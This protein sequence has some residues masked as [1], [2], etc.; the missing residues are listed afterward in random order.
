MTYSYTL[1]IYKSLL[2]VAKGMPAEK[3]AKAIKQI[4]EEFQRNKLEDNSD[5]IKLLLEKANSSLG[6]LKIVTPRRFEDKAQEG[7]TRIV[8]GED[9]PRPGRA[10][11]NWT[12]TN[13]DPDSVDRHYRS[14]KRA[15]FQNNAHAKG[16]F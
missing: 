14:L 1:H 11:S 5:R 6:Y 4:R 12:G 16:V 7:Y 9:K 10:V 3:R 13:M 2:K 8:F 15:G